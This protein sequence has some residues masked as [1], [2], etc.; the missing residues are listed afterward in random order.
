[1][2]EHDDG[3]NRGTVEIGA[4]YNRELIIFCKIYVIISCREKHDFLKKNI[5]KTL[6]LLLFGYS[7]MY[8]VVILADLNAC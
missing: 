8:F 1:M 3:G 7:P 5:Y 2:G 6:M 4:I